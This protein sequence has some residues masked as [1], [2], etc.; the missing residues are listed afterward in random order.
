MVAPVRE[1]N[2]QFGAQ[3]ADQGRRAT[4]EDMGVAGGVADLA[5]GIGQAS[6][7][8]KH[9]EENAELAYAQVQV[10]EAENVLDEK[11]REIQAKATP[12]VSTTDEIKSMTSD[13]YANMGGQYKTQKAQQYVKLHG[14]NQTGK[15]VKSSIAFDVDLAVKDRFVQIGKL[16][17]INQK[18]VLADPG[19]YK[20]IKDKI[21]LEMESGVGLFNFHGDA[22]YKLALREKMRSSIENL[23][24]MAAQGDLQ[25]P[26]VRGM[27]VGSI[28]SEPKSYGKRPDGTEKGS[29]WLGELPVKGGGVATEYTMASDAVKVDGKMIDF[30][31]LVPTLT[32]SE[33]EL[34]VNDVIPNRKEIPEPII[35]KAIDHAKKRISEGK[36]VFA[37]QIKSKGGATDLSFDNVFDKLLSA[38]SGKKQVDENGNPIISKKGAIGIAQVMPGTAPE[39]AKLAGIPWDEQRY[40]YDAEYNKSL[41]KAYLQAKIAEFDG[42][43]VKGLAAYNAGA[44]L[45]MSAVGSRGADWLSAMPQETQQYVKNIAGNSVG[46]DVV[47][48]PPEL[49]QKPAWWDDLSAEKQ[50]AVTR[51]AQT[52]EHQNRNIADR[53]NSKLINDEQNHFAATGKLSAQAPKMNNVTDPEQRQEL[54][55]LYDASSK[56]AGI[57]DK[58]AAEQN[59]FLERNKPEASGIPGDYTYQLKVYGQ[60]ARFVQENQKLRQEDQV[61]AAYRMGF[62]G[63][64]AE[65]K[66]LAEY[67]D[68]E[69]LGVEISNR[70]AHTD[71]IQ[72]TWG[73][74]DNKIFMENEAQNVRNTFRS[75]KVEDQ[76]AYLSGLAKNISKEHFD[77]LTK[78]VWKND[79]EIRG[80]A[81][82]S[83][84]GT[85]KSQNGSSAER[86]S[87][88]ILLGRKV[89]DSNVVKE[90]GEKMPGFKGVLPSDES[91]REYVGAHLAGQYLPETMINALTN[92]VKAH[93]IGNL[94]TKGVQKTYELTES[95]NQT[96]L[97]DSIKTV[98]G[99][100]STVG[101]TKVTRPWGMS[102]AEFQDDVK[103]QANEMGFMGRHYGLVAIEGRDKQYALVINGKTEGTI[104]LNR[105]NHT[106]YKYGGDVVQK[107]K[108]GIY[109]DAFNAESMKEAVGLSNFTLPKGRADE[110]GWWEQ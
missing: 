39:A 110:L 90:G 109:A 57:M 98:I 16:D 29:G 10:A 82:L 3:S 73:M 62:G 95:A 71:A 42:D 19:K 61:T 91:I 17:E 74:K 38:E 46:V 27:I 7:I 76:P 83:N 89:L 59:E 69:K 23:A 78:Q 4:P 36:S 49:K 104:D 14:V 18:K 22:R 70:V 25:N 103:A 105:P 86:T 45:V 56:L 30:P 40:K 15:R 67:G 102:D 37:D 13:Y 53:A 84:L 107:I 44:S 64:Q 1:Y 51:A 32:K 12:G 34:M 6:A 33:V 94:Q 58:P 5:Q 106:R 92:V 8:M 50:V 75:L 85:T 68:G 41:G 77:A 101:P 35:Q 47:D 97:K 72:K 24:Y 9:H 31:T 65:I 21:T 55:T 93:Y 87:E 54:Q 80:A 48:T 60:M 43:V 2:R 26:A 96:Y 88:L 63:K 81:I 79:H 11:E 52:L 99:V 20:E 100:P 108:Y 66:P 28:K